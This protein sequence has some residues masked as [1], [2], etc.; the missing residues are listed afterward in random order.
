[1]NRPDHSKSNLKKF[2]MTM[3][4]AFS[5]ITALI[6]LRHRHSI[7]PS[8]AVAA[9]FFLCTLFAWKALKPVYIVWMRL[10]FVLSWFNTRLILIIFFYLIFTPIGLIMRLFGTDLLDRRIQKQTP[11]YWK[12]K[13]TAE[14]NYE[15]QF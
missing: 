8:A 2:G 5:L 10:A 9:A 1:M 3:G 7:V 14:V 6:F 11:T 12:K 15:R 4:I 13:E